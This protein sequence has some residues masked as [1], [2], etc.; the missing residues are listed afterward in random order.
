M[1]HGSQFR[2]VF[3]SADV[4]TAAAITLFDCDGTSRALAA[5]ERFIIDHIQMNKASGTTIVRLFDDIDAD[6]VIDTGELLISFSTITGAPFVA[7]FDQE[8]MPCG[9][10]RLPKVIASA[11]GLVEVTGT[12]HIVTS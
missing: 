1:N 8:G 9:K 2:I 4:T 7:S 10:G 11:A 3:S 6:G 5:T 12:G